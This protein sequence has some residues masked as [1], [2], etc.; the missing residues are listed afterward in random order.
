MALSRSA[1]RQ[2]FSTKRFETKKGNT[3][4]SFF[5]IVE[6]EGFESIQFDQFLELLKNI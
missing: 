3:S 1:V 6:S 2:V 4:V 5:L